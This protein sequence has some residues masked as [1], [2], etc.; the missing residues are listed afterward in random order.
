MWL[1]MSLNIRTNYK[2][3]MY[4]EP[5]ISYFLQSHAICSGFFFGFWIEKAIESVTY[6]HPIY[7]NNHEPSAYEYEI[8]KI[9]IREMVFFGIT[10]WWDG[11]FS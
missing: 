8:I 7:N 9:D 10:R 4:H 1:S 2:Y 3:F 6:T 11:N 5:I